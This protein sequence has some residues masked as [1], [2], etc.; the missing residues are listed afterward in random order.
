M[1]KKIQVGIVMGSKSDL[2]VMRKAAD[3]L[4][5]L[6]IGYEMRIL[7]AHRTPVQAKEWSESAQERG[8]NLGGDRWCR[9]TSR[10][11]SPS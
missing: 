9:Y 5:S 7:S 6:D 8:L 2:I 10:S 1:S 11:S 3:V 4:K